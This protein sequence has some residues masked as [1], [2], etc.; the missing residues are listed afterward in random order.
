MIEN[1]KIWYETMVVKTNFSFTSG[2]NAIKK[3]QQYPLWDKAQVFKTDNGTEVSAI[4]VNIIFDD[5]TSVKG[6]YMLFISKNEDQYKST[7]CYNENTNY[8]KGQLTREV[9]E[10]VYSAGSA[11]IGAHL[12]TSNTKSDFRKNEKLMVVDQGGQECTDWYWT[13]YALDEHGNILYVLSESYL[14]TTCTE[15]GGG[16]DPPSLPDPDQNCTEAEASVTGTPVSEDLGSRLLE[17]N[18]SIRKKEYTW[19]FL[20]SLLWHYIS[21]EEGVH[22]QVGGEWRWKSLTHVSAKRSGMVIGGTLSLI[23]T[24]STPTVGIYNAGMTLKYDFNGQA[25]CNGSPID[26]SRPD[27]TQDSPVWSVNGY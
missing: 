15:T 21:T 16:T 14:Y 10:K 20:Q 8:F 26:V 7:M 6:D 3:I 19:I 24:K 2:T 17:E 1:A 12:K 18:S 27:V 22:E 25:L 23:V 13:I 4:P 5:G 9:I 11:T